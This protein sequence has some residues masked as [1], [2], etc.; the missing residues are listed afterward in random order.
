[1][2]TM[3]DIK[4][5]LLSLIGTTVGTTFVCGILIDKSGMKY[6]ILMIVFGALLIFQAHALVKLVKKLKIDEVIK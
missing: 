5:R 6:W 2:N 3:G 1:M 4:D